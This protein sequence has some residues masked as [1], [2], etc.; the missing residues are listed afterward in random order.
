[1]RFPVYFKR[2]AGGASNGNP[3]LG[4][5]DA[6]TFSST[7][8]ESTPGDPFLTDCMLAHKLQFDRPT[9]RIAV[10]YWFDGMSPVTLPCDL[11]VWDSKSEKWYKA[12]SGTLTSG[13]L[14]YIR[15]PY[16]A[17]SPAT[18]SNFD[19]PNQSLLVMLVVSDNSEPSGTVHIV[20]GPDSAIF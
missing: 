15:I 1:M 17:D 11:W 13:A 7:R 19:V 6:P 4:D 12:A 8:D 3:T 2:D 14:T 10:G 18:Q 16:L 9:N 20:A 5:D